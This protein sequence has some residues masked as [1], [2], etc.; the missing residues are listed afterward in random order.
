MQL[1]ANKNRFFL[2]FVNLIEDYNSSQSILD[3]IDLVLAAM[4]ASFDKTL[5]YQNN[6]STKL[7]ILFALNDKVRKR[8][9]QLVKLCNKHFE[10]NEKIENFSASGITQAQFYDNQRNFDLQVHKKN[11]ILLNDGQNSSFKEYKGRDIQNLINSYNHPDQKGFYPWQ[12][13]FIQTFFDIKTDTILDSSDRFIYNYIDRF[14][15]TGKSSLLK[16]LRYIYTDADI[17]QLSVASTS[18]LRSAL[19]RIGPKKLYVL[20]LPKEIEKSSDKS[21]NSVIGALEDVKNGSL[22]STM[23]GSLN[24]LLFDIP[25]IVV[26]S[27]YPIADYAEL[28]LDRWKCFEITKNSKKL[29]KL[30]ALVKRKGVS[31]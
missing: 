2:I 15:N 16:C 27:N 24:S 17:C 31:R 22:Q 19:A 30:N 21:L 4:N 26:F 8:N 3:E 23:Y 18:Q 12:K 28:S 9:G 11:L 10:K 14:G 7:V 6:N 29:G 20:D 1:Q 13:S 25:S 5:R